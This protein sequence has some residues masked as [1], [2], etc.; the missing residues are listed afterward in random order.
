[1]RQKTWLEASEIGS[2]DAGDGWNDQKIFAGNTR[3]RDMRNPTDRLTEEVSVGFYLL[4][5]FLSAAVYLGV[6]VTSGPSIGGAFLVIGAFWLCVG[7]VAATALVILLVNVY[8]SIQD[9]ATDRLAVFFATII[10]VSLVGALYLGLL[11]DHPRTA[12]AA[13]TVG[14]VLAPLGLFATVFEPRIRHLFA[15][16]IP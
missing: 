4:V 7:T 9:T 1:M 13:G 16:R 15:E 2:V 3:E 10:L 6:Q 14:L 8:R 12:M 5:A 11:A